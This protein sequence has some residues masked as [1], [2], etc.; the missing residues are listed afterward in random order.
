MKSTDLNHCVAGR[1]NCL[2]K[3]LWL[4]G[5]AGL[6]LVQPAQAASDL[7]QNDGVVSYPG[8]EPSLPVIAATN[9]V[10]NG[11]FIVN[12]AL[13]FNA[14]IQSFY[15]TSDT[16]NYENNGLMMANTGFRFDTR[17]SGVAGVRSMAG[18]FYNSGLVSC[19]STNNLTDPYYGS[20]FIYYSFYGNNNYYPQCIVNATNIVSPGGMEIGFGGR[21]EFT[22]QKVD[23]SRSTLTLEESASYSGIFSGI[24]G[25]T[26]FNYNAN[27]SGTGTS[28]LNTNYWN[29][30]F[31][32]TATTAQSAYINLAPY[33]LYLTNSTAYFDVAGNGSNNIIRCVFIQD[34]S[35]S[36]VAYNVYFDTGGP[37]FGG[38]VTIEWIG[39]YMNPATGI[40]L[41][42]YLYLHNSYLRSTATNLLLFNGIPDN[43][44]FTPSANPIAIGVPPAVAGFNDVFPN[45]E[46]TNRY[47]FANAQLVAS[48]VGLDS[49]VNGSPT[50]LPGRVEIMA[51]EELDMTDAQMTGINY[52]S[53]QSPRQFNGTAGALI[54]SAYSDFNLGVTNGF[55]AVT[56]LISPGMPNLSGNVQAW[57]TRWLEANALGGTNDFRVLIVGSQLAPT[58]VAQIQDMVLHATNSIIISDKLNLTRKFTADAENLTL[59]TNELGTGATSLAGEL[60]ILGTNVFAGSSSL[61]NLRNLTNNGSIRVPNLVQFVGVSN[62]MAVTPATNSAAANAELLFEVKGKKKNVASKSTVKVGTNVYTFVGSL[63]KTVPNQVKVGKTFELSMSNLVAA[64]NGASGAGKSYSLPTLAHPWVTAS[65]LT[66][67]ATNCSLVVTAKEPGVY[68]NDV[69]AQTT[70]TNLIWRTVEGSSRST[71]LA[72]GGLY[73]PATT[74]TTSGLAH[75]HN[76]INTGLISDHGSVIWT[77]N[78]VNGGTISNGLGSFSLNTA[79]ATLTN[80]QIQAGQDVTIASGSV[81]ASNVMIYAGRT[82]TLSATN[83]LDDGGVTNGSIWVV[84]SP[85]GT[86]GN[87]LI[88]RIK[89]AAGD[90]LGTT[91]TNYAAAPNKLVANVWAGQNRGVSNA[92][93]TTN[94]AVGRL[95]L[96]ALGASSKFRFTGASVSNAM[97]VD[98]LELAGYATNFDGSGNLKALTIDPNIT[99]YFAQAMINGDSVAEKLDGKNS[100][101][102]R[103]VSSYAGYYSSTNLVY[104]GYTNT[105]NAALAVS[106]TIDSDGDGI[107][108]SSDPT[109]FPVPSPAPVLSVSLVSAPPVS[110]GVPPATVAPKSAA[111]ASPQMSLCLQWVAAGGET[112][113]LYYRTNLQAGDWLPYPGFSGYYYG[114]DI[115]VP[116]TG[117]SHRLVL[118][119]GAGGSTSVRVFDVLTGVP[120]FYYQVRKE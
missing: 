92:G 72:G 48:S 79:T 41:Q 20:L 23:L 25:I 84:Q 116:N 55:L 95:I 15:E 91:I 81:L 42:N 90:L 34:T 14:P 1:L 117:R 30:Y 35:G 87:G 98:Y 113:A 19:G 21:A 46:V 51:T 7:Y 86:G 111:A 3:W 43:F 62:N 64:I 29:P 85:T 101:R 24:F 71:T 38:G 27:V 28:G 2:K 93:Y 58:A 96:D 16:V 67:S 26:S 31:D 6:V 10:N 94:S 108:N 44:Q 61:P 114:N 110:A 78:F 69:M 112:Y 36:D 82:L 37:G 33:Y 115:W 5:V 40:A 83:L 47:S 17:P 32:L 109:P 120:Q 52:L 22:G 8:T 18:S 97:Y 119:A 66:S 50:N 60:N 118:P 89:P 54:Q 74:N 106:S 77:T 53:V 13:L 49:V 73:V 57:S 103:W 59:T 63:K 45:T 99:I 75:Y 4:C 105:V 107:P 39:S 9:F 80:G 11:T 104:G 56:N 76:F 68:W 100:G 70:S 102:L 65:A 12:H 88:Q